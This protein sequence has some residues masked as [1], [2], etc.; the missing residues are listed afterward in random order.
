[1]DGIDIPAIFGETSIAHR[2]KNAIN[3]YLNKTE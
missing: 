1:M 3:E 2:N